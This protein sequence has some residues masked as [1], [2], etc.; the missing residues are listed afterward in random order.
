[1]LFAAIVN[2]SKVVE[3]LITHGA[4]PLYPARFIDATNGEVLEER[5]A[6]LSEIAGKAD[7]QFMAELMSSEGVRIAKELGLEGTREAQSRQVFLQ[8]FQAIQWKIDV[9]VERNRVEL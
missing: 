7:V 5:T 9:S 4:D 3:A 1:M 6:R 8:G 2:N